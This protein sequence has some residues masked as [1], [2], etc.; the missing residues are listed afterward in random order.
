MCCFRKADLSLCLG[1]SL[2]IVPS[3]N[4]P[5]AAKRNN[6]K[7][8]IVNLQPT[9]HD[10]KADLIINT[11]VDDVMTHLCKFLKIKIPD[12]EKPMVLLKSIHTST[13]ETS[14]NV[15]IKD[16]CL[17]RN[18]KMVEETSSVFSLDAKVQKLKQEN[19]AVLV[20]NVQHMQEQKYS[21]YTPCKQEIDCDKPGIAD[22]VTVKHLVDVAS[23]VSMKKYNQNPLKQENKCS[24]LSFAE[25]VTVKHLDDVES[26]ASDSTSS[27][28][29][30]AICEA[31]DDDSG[32]VVITKVESSPTVNHCDTST[33]ESRTESDE[34]SN[35]V[36]ITKTEN[37]PLSISTNVCVVQR[38]KVDEKGDHFGTDS[39]YISKSSSDNSTFENRSQVNNDRVEH[40]GVR[41]NSCFSSVLNSRDCNDENES[42]K[43]EHLPNI[44]GSNYEICVDTNQRHCNSKEKIS[45]A[46][47][48]CE[49]TRADSNASTSACTKLCNIH[50]SL[51]I[52]EEELN[53]NLNKRE[54]TLCET[55]ME[56]VNK[57]IKLSESEEPIHLRA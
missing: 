22:Q 27:K 38:N 14:L 43:N 7:L 30:S 55:P 48:D 52:K 21:K 13:D 6:G 41:V 57:K 23:D 2:Q 31:T 32:D 24:K 34:D 15:T 25:Q 50:T 49:E 18:N 3:G 51:D 12:F 19:G 26:D 11:Y 53:T 37:L 42:D 56:S 5:L 39:Q 20:N 54:H 17:V 44:R 29:L 4:L 10:K 28:S 9:K 36:I 8:V 45:T 1:T 40:D 47:T 16:D 46:H 35:D 33:I